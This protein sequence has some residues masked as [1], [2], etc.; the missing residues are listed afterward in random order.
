MRAAISTS[1][2]AGVYADF[3]N[4]HADAGVEDGDNVA[5]SAN[6]QQVIDYIAT[7]STGNAV[8]VYGDTNSRYTRTADIG[9][10]N[11]LVPGTSSG[12]GLTDVWIQLER[13][14]IIPTVETLCDNPST[15]D[16]CET[17]D[18]VFYRASP[19]L[20]LRATSFHYA[21]NQFLQPN[22]SILSDHNP[23]LVNF[24]YNAGPNLRQSPFFGGDVS[25]GLGGTWFSDVPILAN[26]TLKGLK[27]KSLSF[28][29][30]SRLDS[31]AVTLTDG[32]TL[33]HGGSGGTEGDLTLADGEYW[34]VATICRGVYNGTGRVFYIKAT[35]SSGNSLSVGKTTSDCKT[36]T[37]PDGWHIIGF[38]GRSGDEIDQIA[39]VYSSK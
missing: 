1:G 4:L 32:T 16:Y 24:T 34:T 10:R 25:T 33:Q 20:D 26:H 39:L 18:K 12:P 29:G 2:S 3:Y 30:G 7:W 19:L 35:T 22:G 27:A 9:L 15:T 14:G 36:Y 23:V 5:R 21:S 13:S 8:L 17:V 28:R 31:V 38:L 6:L 37:A 11:M